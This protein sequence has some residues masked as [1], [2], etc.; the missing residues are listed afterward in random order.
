MNIYTFGFTLPGS[1][2]TTTTEVRGR[3][4]AEAKKNFKAS[5]YGKLVSVSAVEISLRQENVMA[6]KQEERDTLET[7][8]QMVEELGPQS[9]LSTAF[10]GCFEDAESNIEN[11]F[12]DSMKLRWEYAEAQ[13]KSAQERIASLETEK[14]LM[15]ETIDRLQRQNEELEARTL[16]GTDLAH[17]TRLAEADLKASEERRDAAAAAIVEY[18][19]NPSGE[20]FQQAVTDHRNA[21]ASVEAKQERLER[22]RCIQNAGQGD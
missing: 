9:Y 15:Q 3:N 11:D 8:R 4:E 6:T 13:L 18:A 22:L 19:D 16:Q 7:I 20:Q 5:D 12:G 21:T 17:L 1:S 14:R 10:D 2:E